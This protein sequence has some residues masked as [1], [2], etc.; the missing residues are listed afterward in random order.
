[1]V[2][3]EEADPNTPPREFDNYIKYGNPLADRHLEHFWMSSSLEGVISNVS[4]GEELFTNYL[5]YY[6][7]S[8]W[9]FG[10]SDLRSQCHGETVGTII[11]VEEMGANLTSKAS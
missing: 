10:I 1:M 6:G 9:K 7:S 2:S 8:A 11:Q 5:Y 3:E 4:N